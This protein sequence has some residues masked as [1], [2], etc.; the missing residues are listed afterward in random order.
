MKI[1]FII[2]TSPGDN[3]L[4]NLFGV[5]DPGQYK[6]VK[7]LFIESIS[8]FLTSEFLEFSSLIN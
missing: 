7:Y 3:F 4:I 5:P 1:I 6:K 2:N 8:S